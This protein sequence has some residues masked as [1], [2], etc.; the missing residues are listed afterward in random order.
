MT[1]TSKQH[2]SSTIE[3]ETLRMTS[4]C[5]TVAARSRSS[6]AAGSHLCAP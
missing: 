6:P 3:D 1:G 2:A 5:F 4:L